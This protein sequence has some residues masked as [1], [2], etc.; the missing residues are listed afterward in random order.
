LPT[1]VAQKGIE[2]RPAPSTK[3]H[4]AVTAAATSGSKE[5]VGGARGA[6]A[7]QVRAGDDLG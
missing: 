2:M 7:R 3:N 5:A 6:L 1:I 4:S